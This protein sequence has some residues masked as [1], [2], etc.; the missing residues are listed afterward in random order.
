MCDECSSVN[1]K[2]CGSRLVTLKGSE[3]DGLLCCL[4]CR[5]KCLHCVGDDVL[6]LVYSL[7]LDLWKWVCPICGRNYDLE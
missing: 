3:P 4:K 5:A 6:L 1:C 2:F 7:P